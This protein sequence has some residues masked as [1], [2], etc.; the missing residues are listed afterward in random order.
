MFPWDP[1]Q[2]ETALPAGETKVTPHVI[3]V[4][5]IRSQPGPP[6]SPP[7]VAAPTYTAH[8]GGTTASGLKAEH[9]RAVRRGQHPGFKCMDSLQ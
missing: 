1:A 3:A 9:L 8:L 7:T 2:P 4:R 5:R 6:K